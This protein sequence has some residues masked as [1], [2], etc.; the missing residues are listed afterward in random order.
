MIKRVKIGDVFTITKSIQE[1]FFEDCELQ[2]TYIVIDV[3][4]HFVL[5]K[6]INTG[7]RRAVCYGDLIR[8]GLEIQEMRYEVLR[9]K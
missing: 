6:D 4:P 7:I 3:Y 1:K 2:R 8:M 9:R 5:A